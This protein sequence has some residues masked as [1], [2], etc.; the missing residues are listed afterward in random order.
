VIN[1]CVLILLYYAHLSNLAMLD[2]N[3]NLCADIIKEL[4]ANDNFKKGTLFISKILYCSIF[5][6]SFYC[7]RFFF[8]FFK[9]ELKIY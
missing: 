4:T 1:L 6:V 2:D 3:T 7:V 9:A 8:F 5:I